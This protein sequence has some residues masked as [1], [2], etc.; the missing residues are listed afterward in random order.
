MVQSRNAA[1]LDISG[2]E[3][4]LRRA[5]SADLQVELSS[6]WT[7]G[8]ERFDG[9]EYPADRIPPL[10][11][12]AGLVWKVSPQVTAESWIDLARRQHRYSPRDLVDPRI[13]PDGTDGWMSWNMRVDWKPTSYLRTTLQLLNAADASYREFGSGIDAPG[14]GWHLTVELSY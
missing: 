6:T 14:R 2:L 11:G 8:D 9:S 5:L 1:S 13:D 7:T 10:I 3:L 4:G 12:R